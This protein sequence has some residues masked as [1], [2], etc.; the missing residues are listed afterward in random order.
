MYK[1]RLKGWLDAR[2][3]FFKRDSS[4]YKIGVIDIPT[5]YADF[6]G[7]SSG[8][9]DYKSTTKAVRKPKGELQAEGVKGRK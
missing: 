5:F 6:K 1:V 7:M 4:T 3:V 2:M 8:N 9:K